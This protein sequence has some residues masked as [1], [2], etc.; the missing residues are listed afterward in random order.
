MAIIPEQTMDVQE[1]SAMN[2]HLRRECHIDRACRKQ[3]P[4]VGPAAIR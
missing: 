1:S 4:A 2:C 3:L